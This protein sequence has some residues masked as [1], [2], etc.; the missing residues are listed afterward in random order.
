MATAALEKPLSTKT[1]DSIIASRPRRS[2]L[3]YKLAA[4]SLGLDIPN[5]EIATDD[6]LMKATAIIST[7]T[8]DRVGDMLIPVGCQ[9]KNYAKNPVV[10]WNH[11]FEG[12][13]PIGRGDDANKVLGLRILDTHVESDCYFDA[14][15]EDSDLTYKMIKAGFIRATSVRETPIKSSFMR[16]E[17]L[18]DILIV[19]EWEL[20]EWSWVPVGCNP[21]ALAK[22]VELKKLDGTRI[23][24]PMLKS[25][26][27]F[28]PDLKR[29]GIGMELPKER[30]VKLSPETLKAMPLAALKSLKTDNP[31]EPLLDEEM[32]RRAKSDGGEPD[33]E[34]AME[35]ETE[36]D[37]GMSDE[38]KGV[39][40]YGS[41]VIKA[42]HAGLKG[43]V[44][45]LDH[46]MKPLEHEEVRK[47]LGKVKE[48]LEGHVAALEGMHAKA[49]SDQEPLA[50]R[51]SVGAEPMDVKSFLANGMLPTLQVFG[52]GSHLTRVAGAKNLTADQRTILKNAATMLTKIASE[53]KA[54]KEAQST[55]KPAEQSAE[56]L[57]ALNDRL[58][59]MLIA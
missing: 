43:I 25:L 5:Q 48:G 18:G 29:Y 31:D 7:P 34:A 13:R 35:P 21:D 49:Y 57:K 6:V 30:D 38:E 10:L 28:V 27:P 22:A 26:L 32:K 15:F 52:I 1:V 8:V 41:Q 45:N 11:G 53:A 44:D 17:A 51:A 56:Q 4:N 46:A 47:C 16:D 33:D 19:E 14:S 23:R 2:G 9:I 24:G 58:S 37:D 50:N 3:A 20:E 42:C 12:G 39:E 40:P 36:G 55:E 59:K 54:A